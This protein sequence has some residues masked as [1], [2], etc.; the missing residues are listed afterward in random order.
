MVSEID[1]ITNKLRRK[2]Y[3]EYKKRTIRINKLAEK[4]STNMNTI[5]K[6]DD[7][8][9]IKIYGISKKNLLIN[10]FLYLKEELEQMKLIER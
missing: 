2:D 5:A 3:M 6:Y 8:S 4:I 10:N 7:D 1:K 9:L